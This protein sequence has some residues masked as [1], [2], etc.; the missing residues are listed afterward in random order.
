[1]IRIAQSLLS[2]NVR[3]EKQSLPMARTSPWFPFAIRI[4]LM[5]PLSIPS[6]V[7]TA[8]KP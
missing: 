5:P 7:I 6:P 4:V 8:P 1:M 2:A 3:S